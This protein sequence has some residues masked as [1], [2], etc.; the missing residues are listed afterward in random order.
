[1]ERFLGRTLEGLTAADIDL[2]GEDLKKFQKKAVRLSSIFDIKEVIDDDSFEENFRVLKEIVELLQQYQIRYPKKQQ[3]LSDFFERL[4]TTGL[5]QEAGQF[6]TPPPITKF[7]VKSLPLTKIIEKEVNQYP[8]QLP[9]A[10][11]YACGSGHFITELLEE[12]QHVINKL[13]TFSLLKS[14]Q[15]TVKTR[16]DDPYNRAEEYIYG[17]EKDSRLVKVA[18]V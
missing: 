7:I 14:I 12:Y 1:M 2:K 5:K 6:F 11:D 13:K 3:H 10:I 16:Q 15:P 8:A 9:V 18:K 4:L 17:I